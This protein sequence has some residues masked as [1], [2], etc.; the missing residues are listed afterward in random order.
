V[1]LIQIKIKEEL[2]FKQNVSRSKRP[3]LARAH[4]KEEVRVPTYKEVDL[5][6]TLQIKFLSGS[7]KTIQ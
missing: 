1:L 3:D 2:W 4:E 5:W 7:T 6:I